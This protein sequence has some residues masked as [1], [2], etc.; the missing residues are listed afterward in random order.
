ME[1]IFNNKEEYIKLAIKLGNNI[2]Y[3]KSI[4]EQIK[5][6]QSVLFNDQES[7]DE[8]STLIDNI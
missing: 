7:I 2:K 6:K 4:E 1:I 5:E 8:W 3:R